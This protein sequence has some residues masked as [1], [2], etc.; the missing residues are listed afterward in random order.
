[1][2]CLRILRI[3]VAARSTVQLASTMAESASAVVAAL[4]AKCAALTS[5]LDDSA[6]DAQLAA[7][8]GNV[9]VAGAPPA[10]A[11]PKS[12]ASGKED[13]IGVALAIFV[14]AANDLERAQDAIAEFG[15]LAAAEA[16]SYD[17]IDDGFGGDD[18][19]YGDAERP[20]AAAV[21]EC[22]RVLGATYK[23]VLVAMDAAGKAGDFGRGLRY[24]A[25]AARRS[26]TTL[27][28]E[29]YPPSTPRRSAR[30]SMG[31]PGPWPRSSRP[32][33]RCRRAAA[34]A[35]AARWDAKRDAAAALV[36][37]LPPRP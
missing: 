10:A 4:A 5:Q 23:D 17:A 29:L 3:K 24:G 14:T 13:A 11:V 12:W 21:V 7:A 22:L 35:D 28:E 30:R 16:F 33:A 37:A 19:A 6:L 25:G 18:D 15:E 1:M 36:A 8:A 26:A 2:G 34:G 27:A 9:A 32:R 20:A 31:P